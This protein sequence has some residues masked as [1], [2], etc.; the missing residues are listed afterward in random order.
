[1][2]GTIPSI[3]HNE[4]GDGMKLGLTAV[5]CAALFALA[6]GCCEVP[7][8]QPVCPTCPIQAAPVIVAPAQT[9]APIQVTR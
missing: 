7:S 4:K 5:V 2:E 9:A 3:V 8:S 1:M 6:S